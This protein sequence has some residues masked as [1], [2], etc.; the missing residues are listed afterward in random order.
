MTDVVAV[1]VV[2]ADGVTLEAELAPP[3]NETAG[4]TVPV[5]VLSHPHPLYGGDMRNPLID[6]LFR[7]LPLAGI[8]TLRYNFRGAGK[9]G[10]EHDEGRAEQL[11]ARAAFD[12]AAA[13]GAKVVSVGWSFGADVS[14]AASHDQLIGWVAIASPLRIVTPA[15]MAAATDERP[16][17]L[18]VPE[19]DQYRSPT[20][21]A[22][23]TASWANTSLETIEGADHF[24]FGHEQRVA[25]RVAAF[26]AEP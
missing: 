4:A 11:D 1:D 16:K 18:L 14:L 26:C 9:S 12:A 13:L 25:D 7:A 6:A 2:A 3:A 8:S 24:L 15:D 22:E 20:D 23:I 21:A 5:A 10:G 17:L 19:H